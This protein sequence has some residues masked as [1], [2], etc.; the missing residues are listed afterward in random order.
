[1]EKI[2]KNSNKYI[3][4]RRIL[5]KAMLEKK[6]VVFVGSGTSI[7]AGMPSWHDAVKNIAN[8]LGITDDDNIDYMKI[9]Q[10]Y[11]NARGNKEYVDLMRE[12][13]KY[14]EDLPVCDVHRNI[15]ELNTHTIITTNYDCLIEKA[16]EEN[17][18]FIQVIS[19]DRD[20]PYKTVEKEILKIH[21]DLEK[22][23]F[24]LKEDDYIHYSNNFKLIEAYVKSLIATNVVLFVGYSF[25]DPDVKQIFSW[26]K[27]TLVE[28]FQRAYMLEVTRKYDTHEYEYYKNL[29]I[30]IIYAS[31][32]YNNF[33]KKKASKYT[34]LFI[35]YILDE[36]ENESK[37]VKLYNNIMIYS[38]LNYVC[39]NYLKNIFGDYGITIK[40]NELYAMDI[41][42]TESNGLLSEIFLTRKDKVEPM[43]ELIKSVT[44]KNRIKDVFIYKNNKRRSVNLEQI[45]IPE[46]EIAI[47]N[48]DFSELRK[49]RERNEANLTD[50]NPKLYL[51]QAYISYILFDYIKAYRYLR[52]SSKLFYRKK[53]Y[54]W[55]FISEINRKNLGRLIKD[56]YYNKNNEL[57]IE[58]IS[59]EVDALDIEVVYNK[60]PIKVIGE[61]EFLKDL[62]TFE[63]FYRAFQNT[64][65]TS[66]KT[67][68]EA[69]TNYCF[70]IGNP[71][72]K[73]IREQ[74]KD[75]YFYVVY[76]YVMIDMYI[77]VIESYRLF[78]KAIINSVCN[79]DL[80]IEGL[81]HDDKFNMGNVHA[82]I[83]EK[84]D[85]FIIIRYMKN[86]ELKKLLKE[87]TNN[88]IK[89]STET[90]EYLQNVVLKISKIKNIEAPYFVNFLNLAG[91]IE[92]DE[93]L[94]SV[95]LEALCE[96]IDDFF[97]FGKGNEILR[98]L[99]S[100]G[101]QKVYK[102]N[103][104]KKYIINLIEKLLVNILKTNNKKYYYELIKK[105]LSIYN[106]F[107]E[108]YKSENL[109]LLV[110]SSEYDLLIM[111]YPFVSE[112]I[113]NSIREK[114]K[115]WKWNGEFKDFILYKNLVNNN[116]I[117]SEKNIEADVLSILNQIENDSEGHIPNEYNLVIGVLTNLYLNDKIIMKEQV[118]EEIL[119]SN[120][121][122][123]KWLIDM[124]N[125]DYAQ[126]DIFWLNNCT[127]KLLK[128]IG[129]TSSVREKIVKKIKEKYTNGNINNTILRKYFEYFV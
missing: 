113:Q 67:E 21:G 7:D 103:T 23:N 11:Y 106:E 65:L 94:V 71:G 96:R 63:I 56:Y 93:K 59:M 14:G 32:M 50:I 34:N 97:V 79:Y 115:K 48:F 77:E 108:L 9:P 58:K 55:Y 15:V 40:D 45:K 91:Y 116:L 12:I 62:Y 10:F 124:D 25:S 8:K 46:M 120:I 36:E 20:L 89:I 92:L 87:N 54:V 117:D 112:E 4:E 66:K 43:R 61:K 6:L 76:N 102:V 19:H 88:Y 114:C 125:Y 121:P 109:N 99:W 42:D 49:I 5:R 72:Y 98:F 31:E 86:D 68:E 107:G 39:K 84:F 127:D 90:R 128:K 57:E 38:S 73:K 28:N 1:M 27:D 75:Y 37:I 105:C 110:S 85:I 122:I 111:I 22:G 100:A 123:Y 69:K 83:L 24:V 118:L 29:G 47:E 81:G 129:A 82:S 35:R 95:T 70:Y 53:Q 64:Y 33:N 119:Q 3:E 60:I 16:V 52:V 126:F 44:S 80:N 101:D 78:A 17:S 104:H 18:E 26:V 51:E 13:F 74:I 2:S 41:E 30:N